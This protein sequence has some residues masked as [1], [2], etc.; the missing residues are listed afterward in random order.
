MRS[1][2]REPGQDRLPFD[3]APPVDPVPAPRRA[4]RAAAPARGADLV[5]H[6]VVGDGLASRGWPA[7][8]EL[9]IDPRRRPRRGEPALARV[10]ERD[11]VGVFDLELGRAALRTDRGSVWLTSAAQIV[12]AVVLAA[13]PLA[14]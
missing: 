9:L 4:V 12:G 7:G 13:P 10:T 8:T 2:P 6:L 11:V 5:R 1:S 3:V 14:V